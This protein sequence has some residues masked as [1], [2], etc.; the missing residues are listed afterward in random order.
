V[1][2][3]DLLT[4][5]NLVTQFTKA[6]STGLPSGSRSRTIAL[7][8]AW[9]SGKTWLLNEVT[10]FLDG[11]VRDFNPWLYSD[12]VG[13]F[14]GF[15][16]LILERIQDRLARRRIGKAL[17]I[18]GPSL[19]G[20]G[21]DFSGSAA[22]VTRSIRGMGSPAEIRNA[23]AKAIGQESKTSY[24]VID[25][26]DRLTPDEL[27]MMFKLL[28]LLG[29]LPGVVYVLAYDEE[30]LLRL[31]MRTQIA[32]GSME[33]ARAYLE[34]VVETKIAIPPMSD[35]LKAALVLEPLIKF[36]RETQPHF[37]DEVIESIV[38]K[39]QTL[40]FPKL[41]TIRLCERVV[42]AVHALP[43]SLYGEINY[44]DWILISFLKTVE[45]HALQVV[46]RSSTDLVGSAHSW[47]L[48]K[49]K[50]TARAGRIAKEIAAESSSKS[51]SANLL[52]VIDEMFPRFAATRVGLEGGGR[53]A[54]QSIDREEYFPLY[55]DH[56]LPQGA[57]SDVAIE[58]S[59]AMLANGTPDEAPL[60]ALLET[61]PA[62]VM[63][64]VKRVWR[65]AVPAP[66]LFD[67]LAALWGSPLLEYKSGV[68]GLS[69]KS[70]VRILANDLL[71]HYSV[72]DLEDLLERADD[73]SPEE[74]LLFQCL[75]RLGSPVGSAHFVDWAARARN[76]LA[77]L[78]ERQLSAAKSPIRHDDDSKR[79]FVYLRR[80]DQPASRRAISEMVISGRVS[81]VDAVSLVL[82][83]ATD[84]DDQIVA[85]GVDEDIASDADLVATL[86]ATAVGDYP[87]EWNEPYAFA[88]A[89]NTNPKPSAELVATYVIRG[90]QNGAAESSGPI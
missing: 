47:L 41:E 51:H 65:R 45:P 82:R 8:G 20:F 77:E 39:V 80:L 27:L 48:G 78:A 10:P 74:D 33:R 88:T 22:A 61:S 54:D 79:M 4:R 29:D 28:R 12:E 21:F 5:N 53:S 11:P 75:L 72:K 57:V 84:F 68:F 58:L 67:F 42:T 14:R 9:G 50:A 37:S 60:V 23:I 87:Q 31:M 43:A 69:G 2:Q 56:G 59:L 55:F 62:D 46:Q 40:L 24:I 63:R 44:L 85:M 18:V 83:P 36:G 81:N 7:T 13:L 76:R 70:S 66:V 38:E 19:K 73:S 34:K 26:L 90:W 52:E 17:D 1:T 71:S 25:D 89:V 16:V 86:S 30:T 3:T 6:I 49:E 32:H 35:Q 15:A 64:V